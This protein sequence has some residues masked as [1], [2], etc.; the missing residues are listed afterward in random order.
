MKQAVQSILRN[1]AI[2]PRWT[3]MSSSEEYV[4]SLCAAIVRDLSGGGCGSAVLT[5]RT[6]M[7][8]HEAISDPGAPRQHHQDRTCSCR[9][10]VYLADQW[11]IAQ[12]DKFIAVG[13]RLL[14]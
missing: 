4:N 13:L 1:L 12:L 9:R 10:E 11:C 14:S 6:L 3:E 7:Y 2:S 8:A 5:C